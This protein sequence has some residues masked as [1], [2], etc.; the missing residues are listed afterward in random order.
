MNGSPWIGWSVAVNDA[1][2]SPSG[3]R[4]PA[5]PCRGKLQNALMAGLPTMA[6][7]AANSAAMP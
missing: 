3:E 6:Y 2:A 4:A 7:P 5:I 1:C